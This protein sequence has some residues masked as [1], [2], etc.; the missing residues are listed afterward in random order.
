M[1]WL[2][3]YFAA[4]GWTITDAI[5][6]AD[7]VVV[8]G[9]GFNMEK[10][11]YSVRLLGAADQRRKES[12]RLFIVGCI[13]EISRERLES[14]F[15]AVLVPPHSLTRFDEL[16]Q[17]DVP[18]TAVGEPHL[19]DAY[20]TRAARCFETSERHAD[21]GPM[22]SQLRR[23]LHESGVRDR[24][25]GLG[26]KRE[27]R[28]LQQDDSLFSIRVATGCAGT[29]SFCA[30]RFACGPLQSKPLDE[31]VRE[32]D[33]GLAA[34][35]TRFKLVAQDLGC[36]GQDLGGDVVGL[37][38]AL[39]ARKGDFRMEL[40][41]LDTRWVIE[42]GD[43]LRPLLAANAE[44]IGRLAIPLQSGSDRILELMRREH[45]GGD[46]KR[47]L[48]ELRAAVP[49][50]LLTT[51][52]LVGFPTET[53]ADVQDTVALLRAVRFD[54]VTVYDYSDRPGTDASRMPGT[55]PRGVIRSRSR[56]LRR[57]FNGTRASL[58]YSLEGLRRL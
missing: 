32:F 39:F 12:S 27:S 50:V 9:C 58:R 48:C 47:A 56:R 2:Y 20:R 54:H 16:V 15:D 8:T 34:G 55:V 41:D 44:R 38:R 49:R 5:E 18:L 10:E 43:E 35:R 53:E 19:L 17:A 14:S 26:F 30:I 25:V 6:E 57:E 22:T 11:E 7:L 37:L 13:A 21:D 4:N 24:M 31:V 29:C 1:A 40:V 36:Y 23:L 3:D 42:Y 45:S 46:A 51:H 33:A 28:Y 52:V